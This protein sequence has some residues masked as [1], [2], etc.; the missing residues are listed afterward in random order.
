MTALMYAA[1]KCY[2]EI[3]VDLI[4]AGANIYDRNNVNLY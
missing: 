3:V 1:Y 2:T 4:K